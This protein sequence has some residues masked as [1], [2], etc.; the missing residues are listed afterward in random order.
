MKLLSPESL[1]TRRSSPGR[2]FLLF[3]LK[4]HAF[5]KVVHLGREYSW[6]RQWVRSAQETKQV[7][8]SVSGQVH[9]KNWCQSAQPVVSFPQSIFWCTGMPVCTN[10]RAPATYLWS[11]VG[12]P[13]CV[14]KCTAYELCACTTYQACNEI[15]KTCNNWVFKA[16]MWAQTVDCWHVC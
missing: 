15:C 16:Q 7:L 12:L 3:L 2:K 9:I 13:C 1:S 10:C 5:K 8:F 4:Q 14:F 6:L 11:S